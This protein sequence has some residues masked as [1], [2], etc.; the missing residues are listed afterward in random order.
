MPEEK[1]EKY[2]LNEEPVDALVVYCSDPRFQKA[3]RHFLKNELGIKN[4]APLSLGGSIHPFGQRAEF[5]E[6]FQMLR[7]QIKFFLEEGKISR[8]VIINHDDCQWY[9]KFKGEISSAAIQQKMIRDLLSAAEYITD[10][11]SVKVETYFA[12]LNG[13]EII[14]E[15]VIE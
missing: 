5:M 2:Y 3:F 15:E 13:K 4:P 9:K 11:F 14:F 7:Q 10:N 8:V 6:N 12:R 1:P